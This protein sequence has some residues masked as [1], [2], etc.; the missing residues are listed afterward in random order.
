MLIDVELETFDKL[1]FGDRGFS[2]QFYAFWPHG[3]REDLIH[4]GLSFGY[5]V[6]HYGVC[7]HYTSIESEEST[8]TAEF[9]WSVG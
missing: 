9:R 7:I 6:M 1:K 4:F 2:V 8:S 5:A 3:P